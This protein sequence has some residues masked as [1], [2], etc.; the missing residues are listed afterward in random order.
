MRFLRGVIANRAK[1]TLSDFS[2]T[3]VCLCHQAAAYLVPAEGGDACGW[4]VN[5]GL[6]EGNSSLLPGFG[7]TNKVTCG[8]DCQRPVSASSPTLDLE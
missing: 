2:L 1:F 3:P 7:L 4:E 5:A 8:V 6:A